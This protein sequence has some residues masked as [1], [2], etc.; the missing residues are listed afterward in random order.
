ME[1]AVRA[2]KGESRQL[3]EQLEDETQEKAA[4]LAKIQKLEADL[5]EAHG[6]LANA[7]RGEIQADKLDS[8]LALAKEELERKGSTILSLEQHI[9]ECKDEIK[10][11]VDEL[12][13]ARQGAVI[14][15]QLQQEKLVKHHEESVKDLELKLRSTEREAA[16]REDALRHEVDELRKRW[17]D[18]VRRADTLSMDIQSSTAPLMRQ[19]ESAERQN[20]VRAAA[21]AEVETKLRSELEETVVV[22]ERL[23]KECAEIR[24]K[25]NRLE[26]RSTELEEEL[27]TTRDALE[28]KTETAKQLEDRLRFMETEGARLKQ[29]WA[30]VER[31]ANEGVARVRSEMTQTVVDSEARYRS[32]VDS[33][34]SELTLEHEKVRSLE[35]QV[36]GLLN[37][38]DITANHSSQTLVM[39]SED[40]EPQKLR[41]S[42]G[43]AQILAGA[44]GLDGEPDDD[45][46]QDGGS[47]EGFVVDSS[48]GDSFAAIEELSSRLKAAKVEL[49]E[50]QKRLADSER[51]RNQLVDELGESRVAKEKLPLFEAKV[52]EL[53]AESEE[54]ALEI[55]GLREDIDEVREV[56]RAQLNMLIE[57]KAKS[58]MEP[59]HENGTPEVGGEEAASE[60]RT[61]DDSTPA[62]E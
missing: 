5:K 8:E 43:Q 37:R 33:L 21:S 47:G 55:M 57:E 62:V 58:V 32:Q 45:D 61:D 29:E 25:M 7:R 3:R 48:T 28:R 36:H 31:L 51:S 46:E 14:D 22:N 1:K 16:I 13:S 60:A 49:R 35:Q 23:T 41:K 11:L 10:D 39:N 15:S 4:A 52:K 50:L 59:P 56:Y 27:R 53:T 2:A 12:E 54:Q 30:E 40:Q 44:L 18:A 6:N 42:V 9:K 26:R 34:K 17:Q 19:L 24:T 20:R 38:P